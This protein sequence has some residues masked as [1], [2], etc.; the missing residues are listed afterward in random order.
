[1]VR[2]L[3]FTYIR[4]QFSLS[5][6]INEVITSL[7]FYNFQKY[8]YWIFHNNIK[9]FTKSI[10]SLFNQI[11]VLIFHLC[12]KYK[13]IN[14]AL[15]TLYIPHIY[16]KYLKYNSSFE[17]HSN[18]FIKFYYLSPFRTKNASQKNTESSLV[19]NMEKKVGK[20]SGQVRGDQARNIVNHVN[21]GEEGWLKSSFE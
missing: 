3:N 18:L 11:I 2:Q 6:V 4:L 10:F 5:F 14:I 21:G 8:T 13:Y 16:R 7:G 12:Y 20:V 1:M 19:K 9:T 17:T 15:Y